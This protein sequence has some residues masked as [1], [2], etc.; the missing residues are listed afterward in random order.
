MESYALIT[1]ASSG[2][3]VEFAKLLAARGYS[4]ILTARNEAALSAQKEAL[5][6][7]YSVAVEC[8]PCDLSE[9]GAADAL[10]AEVTAR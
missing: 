2:L 4:L 9:Q 8:I 5:A 3:G 10:W 1:G 7:E 6:R